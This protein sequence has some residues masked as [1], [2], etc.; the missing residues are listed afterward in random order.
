VDF[1]DGNGVRIVDEARG[2]GEAVAVGAGGWLCW[3]DV[4]PVGA[5]RVVAQA[6]VP[7]AEAADLELRLDHPRTGLLAGRL[8]VP[9]GTGPWRW[10]TVETEWRASAGA[11]PYDVYLVFVGEARLAGF[12]IVPE[13]G[14]RDG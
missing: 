4:A 1:D 10:H 11:G 9:A 5:G 14:N 12:G 2:G 7:G 3:R 8:T 13:E 6:A